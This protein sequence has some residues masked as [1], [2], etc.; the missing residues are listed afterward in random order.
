MPLDCRDT[1]P[2]PLP[3]NEALPWCNSGKTM[4]IGPTKEFIATEGP[5]GRR[6]YAAPGPGRTA[7]CGQHSMRLRKK[8]NALMVCSSHREE[9]E[10][11]ATEGTLRKEGDPRGASDITFSAVKQLSN[12][13][14]YCGEL[15]RGRRRRRR[16]R[17]RHCGR[18]AAAR[19]GAGSQHFRRARIWN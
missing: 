17:I 13:Q 6:N 14:P 4:K 5:R 15:R 3:R 7:R 10:A 8:A 19:K 16:R 9:E 12:E 1:S 11:R 18:L 2:S